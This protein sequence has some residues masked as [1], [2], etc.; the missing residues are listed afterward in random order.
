MK[1][2]TFIIISIGI[3][4]I[5]SSCISKPDK[6]LDMGKNHI[7]NPTEEN[8]EE[9]E[10]VDEVE[11]LIK[12]MTLDEK[13]GQLFIL[14]LNGTEIDDHII[15]MIEKNHIGGLI[16]F[17]YNISHEK[18]A[19]ELLNSLKKA[20]RSNPVPLFLS[21]DEEGGRVTR[22][23]SSFHKLPEAKRIGDINDR[24]I[25]LEYGR[26]LG[27]RVKSLGFNMN[28]AP[29]LDINSNPQNPVIGDRAFG[30]NIERVVDNGLQVMEG[31][32]SNNVIPVV[33]HF[34][35]HGD[36]SMDSHID[37]PLV[38]KDM[39]E[40]E[41]LELV[42]FVEAIKNGADGIMVGHILFP[43]IDKDYP[44]TLSYEIINSLLREKLSY[45]GVVFSDDMTMGAIVKNYSLGEAAVKF[46][47]AGGD[48]LLICHGY[49]NQI[50]VLNRVK[51]E[52]HKESIS[53]EELDE[54]V[55]RIIK[56]KEKYDI[57]DWLI[58]SVDLEEINSRT[59]KL[60]NEIDSR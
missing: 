44:A 21:I 48:I 20:N 8:L 57:K 1:K 7:Q 17:K 30:S 58:E 56:L 24:T 27:E 14:G 3:L 34:P 47:K 25:S 45:D 41:E 10:E 42:P 22:L 49:E 54:K 59:M 6:D 5:L 31:I 18:Q 33:K 4:F 39:K 36:T 35:G 13:I 51:E 2:R 60:L 16:L 46:L 37:I 12:S 15:N 32:K 40:L 9:T 28:F 26:I 50:E 55:Y 53:E 38:D 52:I 29:V 23:P 19:V 11:E 43:Q